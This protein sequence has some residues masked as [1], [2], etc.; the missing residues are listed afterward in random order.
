MKRE[1]GVQ[2]LSVQTKL[3]YPFLTL[4]QPH[5]PQFYVYFSPSVIFSQVNLYFFD[6]LSVDDFFLS[7]DKYILPEPNP[8]FRLKSIGFAGIEAIAVKPGLNFR[9]LFCDRQ[10]LIVAHRSPDTVDTD[11][12]LV[13]IVNVVLQRF[14]IQRLRLQWTNCPCC[15]LCTSNRGN[16]WDFVSQCGAPN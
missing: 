13:N 5:L 16:N 3:F 4:L 15:C 1:Y 12:C 10:P 14:H 2:R 9:R 6:N 8:C 7:I 11:H